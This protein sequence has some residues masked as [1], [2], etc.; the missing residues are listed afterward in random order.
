MAALPCTQHSHLPQPCQQHP[1][2][3][4]AEHRGAPGQLNSGGISPHS[5]TRHHAA[6][7]AIPA[8]NFKH[9]GLGFG[10][11][12]GIDQSMTA[13]LPSQQQH[14]GLPQVPLSARAS[15]AG[16]SPLAPGQMP[17]ERAPQMPE[18]PCAAITPAQALQR[19]SDQLSLFEQVR[20]APH[21]SSASTV[22]ADSAIDAC[23]RQGVMVVYTYPPSCT[24][25]VHAM[26]DMAV[27]H[28]IAAPAPAHKAW[29]ASLRAPRPASVPSSHAPCTI[30][31][32]THQQHSTLNLTTGKTPQQQQYTPPQVT[33]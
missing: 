13:R 17:A 27:Q 9:E 26:V 21:K 10:S 11:S 7:R 5:S 14:Q 31:Y 19:H 28:T 32:S 33:P 3:L 23:H 6:A 30:H 16:R 18:Q 15:V 12:G 8:L 25:T 29:P 22:L 20:C 4:P 2:S 24:S 1:S